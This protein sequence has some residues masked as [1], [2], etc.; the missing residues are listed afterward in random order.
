MSKIELLRHLY[1]YNEWA[2]RQL[3]GAAS[4][5]S[6]EVL[7][8]ERTA[9]GSVMGTLAH[10]VS[11]QEIWLERWVRGKNPKAVADVQNAKQLAAVKAVYQ[12]S[13]A[14]LR[15]YLGGLIDQ[16][17]DRNCHYQN[18]IGD[19]YSRVLWQLMVHVANHGTYHR[20][21]IAAALSALGHSPGDLDFVY[22][23][24]RREDGHA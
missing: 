19:P 20:G 15:E 18:S 24:R 4:Q 21:E 13:H 1:A 11:S 23:E 22:W 6:D 16:D 17:V 9:F 7:N 2:D 12:R 8:K 14:A 3:L 5:V 10:I